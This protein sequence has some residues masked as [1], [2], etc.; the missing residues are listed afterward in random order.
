MRFE[1]RDGFV[2]EE[3]GCASLE[4]FLVVG[5][6]P[7]RRRDDL[8]QVGDRAFRIDEVREYSLQGANL[9][10]AKGRLLQAAVAML[11]VGRK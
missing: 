6:H 11:V 7:V 3:V 9:P 1:S 4:R 10:L 2:F 8:L 5:K